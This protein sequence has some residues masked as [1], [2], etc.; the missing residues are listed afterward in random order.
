MKCPPVDVPNAVPASI[1]TRNKTMSTDESRYAFGAN[2][3]KFLRVLND[4]RIIS[5]ED[6]LRSM[7]ATES[8]EGKAFVDVGCGS[9]LF[10]LAAMRLG[11]TRVHSLDY[12]RE[13]VA[14]AKELRRRYFPDTQRWTVV[15]GDALDG[16]ALHQLGEWD[17]VYSWGVLHH[18]GAM[19]KALENVASLVKPGGI[20]Y[21]SIYNDQGRMSRFWTAVKGTYNRGILGRAVVSSVFIPY[22]TCWGLIADIVRFRNPWR[23]YREYCS[24]RGMSAWHDWHDW[25]GGYPFEVATPEGIFSFYT[26]RGLTMRRLKTCGGGLGCNEFVFERT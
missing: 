22:F 20:L 9:G 3:A 6:S 18:T 7:L 25:L 19:W 23:R 15:R 14:C 26:A 5:A 4:E 12:D 13:S 21:V 17:V 10:S 2:W 16:E 8:L 24:R 1:E 11:A